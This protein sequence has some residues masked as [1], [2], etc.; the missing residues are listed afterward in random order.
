MAQ[1]GSRRRL[2]AG[3][4][5]AV[6]PGAHGPA[7]GAAHRGEVRILRLPGFPKLEVRARMPGAARGSQDT[8]GRAWELE[9]ESGSYRLFTVATDLSLRIS[10]SELEIGFSLLKLAS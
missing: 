4:G 5:L 7:F 9:F 8:S 1:A 2:G 6:P 3:T 10:V